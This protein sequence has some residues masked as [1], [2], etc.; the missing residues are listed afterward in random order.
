MKKLVSL[1]MMTI[2]VLTGCGSSEAT[3]DM[4]GMT[5]TV[6][7]NALNEDNPAGDEAI[8]AADQRR[9]QK[10]QMLEEFEAE[11]GVTLEFIELPQEDQLETI[12]QSVLA[13]DPV[14]DVVRVSSDVY[15]Q[16]V[17]SD[18]LSEIT[19]YSNEYVA[20]NTM[21]INWPVDAG[22][23]FGRTYGVSRDMSAYPELLA[24]DMTLLQEAGM[25]K[26]PLQMYKDDEWTWDNARQYFLDI[27][28][29]LGD[30]VTVWAAEPYFLTKYAI[31][32][33]GIV[34]ITP[35]GEVNLTNDKTYEALDF[36]KGLY[37]DGLIKFYLD[38]EGSPM[39]AAAEGEWESG[40]AVFTTLEGW[41]S[42]CCIKTTDKE[43]GFVPYPVNNGINKTDVSVP[44]GT[45]DMY[46]VP[47]G[48]ENVGAASQVAFYLNRQANTEYYVEGNDVAAISELWM[49]TNSS[50]TENGQAFADVKTN[51]VPDLSGIFI[52]DVD[53]STTEAVVNYF[54]NG[55]SIA[56]SFES[57]S[58]LIEQNVEKIETEMEAASEDSE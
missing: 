25:D 29:S 44:A 48:V 14:A 19:E 33:N 7:T 18:M 40:N 55:E 10:A 6:A 12:T 36:Y 50:E 11:T 52:G 16:L 47:K 26:T 30:D 39:W 57:G 9:E 20:S 46:I 38:E 32:S 45:G 23:V 34:P 43:Y 21:P 31:A 58:K 27:Q 17:I 49:S 51:A 1:L 2:I 28:S 53:F 37:D 13:G 42:D 4:N 5:I 54:V 15:Q 24:Y 8:E 41:R 3:T 35:N 22:T 56:S